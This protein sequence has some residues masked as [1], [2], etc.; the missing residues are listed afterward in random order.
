MTVCALL[1]PGKARMF[2]TGAS[3]ILVACAV[4]FCSQGDS[5]SSGL[6]DAT[7]RAAIEIG[8]LDSQAPKRGS[9]ICAL[10]LSQDGTLLT[11]GTYDGIASLWEFQTLNRPLVQWQAHS[12]KVSAQAFDFSGG[13]LLTAGADHRLAQWSINTSKTPYLLGQWKLPGLATAM[14]L[15]SDGRTLAVAFGDRLEIFEI[16]RD[17]LVTRSEVRTHLSPLRA[18]AFSPL[19]DELAGGGG[20]DNFI[21]VWSLNDGQLSPRCT[22][23]GYPD[24]WVRGL[25]YSADGATLVSLDTEGCVLAWNK[26]G[27]LIGETH[28]GHSRQI[29][30][31]LSTSG[32]TILTKAVS[33]S[34]ARLSRLPENW[35]R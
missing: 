5:F 7:P 22:F 26:G 29:L 8:V 20:G 15:A 10:A 32:Q 16:C 25:A 28:A 4:C 27:R 31:A 35:W 17:R 9:D 14:A 30:V 12:G 3:V 11:T 21:R 13:C 1:M 19:G 24:H 18:L 23:E 33:E 34:A 2:L 6:G